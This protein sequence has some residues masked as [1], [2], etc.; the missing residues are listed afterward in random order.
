MT[1]LLRKPG[2]VHNPRRYRPV[3]VHLLQNP[4]P[5]HLQHSPFV[6]GRVRHEVMERLVTRLNVARINASCYRLDT[7][8]LAWQAQ[9]SQIRAKRLLAIFVTKN[10]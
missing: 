4:L 5:S 3:S 10:P 8:A 7:L 1:S 6:P 2:V 9:T